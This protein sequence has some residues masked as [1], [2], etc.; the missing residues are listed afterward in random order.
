MHLE[1]TAIDVDDAGNLVEGDACVMDSSLS[2]EVR[3]P[4]AR[5]LIDGKIYEI[6]EVHS[7]LRAL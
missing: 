2:D 4:V 1:I 3:I 7:R 5:K 6:S